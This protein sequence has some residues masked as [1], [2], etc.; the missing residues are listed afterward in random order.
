M[1]D[2]GT[3]GPDA[4]GPSAAKRA[5]VS[6]RSLPNGRALVG[7]LLVTVAA[8]GAFVFANGGD[9]GPHTEFLVLLRDIDAGDSI[10]AADVAF[11]PMILSP[12]LARIAFESVGTE[13]TDAVDGATALRFLHAGGLLLTPDLRRATRIGGSDTTNIHEL[14]LPV[15]LDRTPD[16]L[17]RGDLVTILAYDSRNEETWVAF[18]DALV[19]AFNT[20]SDSF[21]SSSAGR[22]TLG[23][24]ESGQV[25][26]GAHLSFLELTVVLTTRIGDDDFPG[27]YDG[28]LRT[29]LPNEL[30]DLAQRSRL[31][32]A[33]A[34]PSVP[35][36]ALADDSPLT[37]NGEIQ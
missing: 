19:L 25:L 14:T 9:S 2:T 18:E 17:A 35:F 16:L 21:G 26:R 33:P 36:S 23:L 37:D 6:R 24:S 7:A 20:Q 27:H 1:T 30:I 10:S 5:I 3:D 32:G 34:G 13:S 11:E 4:A 29:D 8:V 12:E 15:P 28:P 31:R 22:L